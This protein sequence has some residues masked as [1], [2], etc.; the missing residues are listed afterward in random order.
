[1]DINATLLGQAIAFALLI[2]FTVKFIWPPLLDAIDERREK[3]AAGLA[4]A[5]RGTRELAEA[6]EKVGD[7]IRAAREEA[8]KI[9]DLANRR[10]V[11]MLDEAKAQA[12][13]EGERLVA[14]AKAEIEQ[15]VARAR[16]SLR[17]E[18]ASIAVAGA[19]RI[20]EREIDPAAHVQMLEDLAAQI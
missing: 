16:Q 14:G 4:A 6:D 15:E 12:R 7:L 2:G 17:K 13:T 9:V 1:M 19:G 20:L 8:Q 5:D 18:V 10:S 3:I 11:E